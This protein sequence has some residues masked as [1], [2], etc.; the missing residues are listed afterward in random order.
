MMQN[1]LQRNEAWFKAREG[2]LTASMFAGACGLGPGSRQQAWRRVLGLETFEGNAATDWGTENEPVALE[3]YKAIGV[4]KDTEIT[5]T[6]FVVHPEH[7]WLGA[8]PDLLIGS[9]GLGEIK[10]PASQKLYEEVPP[11]Y[12]CQVQ[13]QLEVTK[14][15]WCDFIVWTPEAMSITRIQRSPVYWQWMYE[16][17]AEFWMYVV[18]E[19]EPPRMKREPAPV[20]PEIIGATEIFYLKEKKA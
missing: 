20:I 1:D 3:S 9:T 4:R 8:S 7:E 13:G 17:L 18:A 15:E 19:V 12:L 11:Y 16:R 5:L 2:K 10:C 14:R 6:G